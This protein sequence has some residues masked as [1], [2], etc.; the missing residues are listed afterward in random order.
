M[1]PRS[2]VGRILVHRGND[3]V[4]PDVMTLTLDDTGRDLIGQGLV[5]FVGPSLNQ[6]E[7]R[8]LAPGAVLLPPVCQ[9]DLL[10]ACEKYSPDVVVMIDGEFG[11]TL[12]VWHKEVLFALNNGVRV[13]GASSMGA[14]R[15]AEL[16]RFGMEGVGE[17]Y[18]HYS[19]G[20]LTA[21]EDVALLHADGEHGWRPIT[22]PMVNVWATVQ[23]LRDQDLLPGRDCDALQAAADV[24]HFSQR[25]SNA[26]VQTLI[27]QGRPDAQTLVEVFEA[28]FV[29][30]KKLD[31]IE[32]ITTALDHANLPKPSSERP[33][34]LFGR[35]GEAMLSS[36]TLVPSSDHPLR[37]YQLVNDVA[38][39]DP[40]FE[41]LSQRALDRAVVLEYAYEAGV[42]PTPEEVE[43]ETARFFTMI[44]VAAEE[45]PEWIAANDFRPGELE[46]LLTDE[47]RRRHMQRWALDVR[48][49]ERNRRI[50]L[51]QLHLE[52]RYVDAVKA[53]SRRRK[54]TDARPPIDWPTDSDTTIDLVSRHAINVKWRLPIDLDVMASDHGYD[55][56]SGLVTALLDATAARQEASDRRERL[57]KLFAGGEAT[58]RVTTSTTDV[59]ARKGAASAHSALESY[60]M[61]AFALAFVDLGVADAIA[62]GHSSLA[63]IADACSAPVDRMARFLAASRNAGFVRVDDD[64]WSLT[65][66]GEVFRS[67]HHAS[68]VHYARDLREI[69]LP[70][71]A[72]L[73][74]VIRGAEVTPQESEFDTDLAFSAA[75]WALATDELI[76][77]LV[78]KDFT[79]SVVDVGG[80]LG[81]TAEAIAKRCPA[82]AVSILERPNVADKTVGRVDP[83][84]VAV[85]TAESFPGG[86]DI[87][88]MSRVLCNLSDADAAALLSA[89][90]GWVVEE[91]EVH[92]IDGVLSDT[93]AMSCMDLFNLTRFGGAARTE[94]QWRTLAASTGFT[95]VRID[96]FLGPFFDIVLRPVASHTLR[97]SQ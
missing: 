4:W 14:L 50:I 25:S 41:R 26:L 81:R 61:T 85:H 33:R 86:A 78:P 58:S 51:D 22:W 65:F 66:A 59:A 96:S 2:G 67:D 8:A 39:H 16:D 48:L 46:R 13:F 70:A 38:L 83:Y 36:D 64:T 68:M 47:A 75:T 40:D 63:A 1:P 30:Q 15:A 10:S 87:V 43:Q 37:R 32:A 71:W 56:V 42:E 19:G 9:G 18:R 7:A 17:I 34:H 31:A 29:D 92:V 91:G 82:A 57:A 60:Q 73:A 11:Q 53:A 45:I 28:N 49:Y 54:L 84:R 72:R 20:F 97:R 6:D 93:F 79:G 21:D 94:P 88:T 5:V 74:E 23:H 55:G 80:G 3:Q 52:N 27:A 24:L 95:V 44:G 90:R 62:S 76:A 12:S 35:I 89:V 69:S 77:A